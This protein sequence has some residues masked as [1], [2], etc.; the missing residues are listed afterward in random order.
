MGRSGDRNT[1]ICGKTFHSGHKLFSPELA[2]NPRHH[3]KLRVERYASSKLK[4]DLINHFYIISKNYLDL[5]KKTTR[6][7]VHHV[8][9]FLSQ[10]LGRFESIFTNALPPGK[11]SLALPAPTSPSSPPPRLP[12]GAPRSSSPLMTR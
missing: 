5:P 8:S 7:L 11:H 4:V 3:F 2:A 9:S 1:K 12:C 6:L 10:T